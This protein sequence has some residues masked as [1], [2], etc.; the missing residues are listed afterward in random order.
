MTEKMLRQNFDALSESEKRKFI[1]AGGALT[2][3]P[4]APA[5]K[6]MDPSV[7]TRR[8]FE[9]LPPASRIAAVRAGRAVV[10]GERVTD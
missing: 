7:L 1:A 6:I 5:A 10:D 4:P 2:D 9:A 8:E 3:P